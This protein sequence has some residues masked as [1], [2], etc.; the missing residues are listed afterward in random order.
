MDVNRG[1]TVYLT[2]DGYDGFP[3]LDKEGSKGWLNVHQPPPT[4]PLIQWAGTIH[5]P[6]ETFHLDPN[7]RNLGEFNAEYAVCA[8]EQAENKCLPLRVLCVLC[9]EIFNRRNPSDNGGSGLPVSPRP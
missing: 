6:F 4:L 5:S 8:E 3:S 9:V 2:R 1:I 7:R